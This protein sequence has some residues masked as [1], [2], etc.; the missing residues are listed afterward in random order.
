MGDNMEWRNESIVVFVPWYIF[1][2]TL[3]VF[4]RTLNWPVTLLEKSYVQQKTIYLL[5]QNSFT[6]V[7]TVIS[8]K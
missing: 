4:F 2:S 8:L 6:R 5:K 7:N 3:K 1:P